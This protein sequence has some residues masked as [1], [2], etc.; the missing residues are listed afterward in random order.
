MRILKKPTNKLPQ[1]KAKFVT[2]MP[3]GLYDDNYNGGISK[4]GR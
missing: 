2:Q 3:Q 4:T 1:I